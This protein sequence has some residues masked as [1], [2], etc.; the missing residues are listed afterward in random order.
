MSTD[1]IINFFWIGEYLNK[2]CVLTLKS[3]L[4]YDH[5]VHLWTYEKN[6][7]NIIDGVVI[8]DANEILNY[9]KVFSYK[10]KGD[11]LKGTYGGFSDI[12][13]YH[14]INNVGG[15]YCDTDVTCL[16]NFSDIPNQEYILRPHVRTNCVA[17]IFKSPKNSDFLKYCIEQT[18]KLID[19]NNSSWI[20][21]LNILNDCVKKF[22]FEK[23]IVSKNYFGDE[24]FEFL[25]KILQ[26]PYK[27][28]VVLPTHAIHWCNQA[29]TSG[30]WNKDIQRNWEKTMPCTLF[31]ILLRKHKIN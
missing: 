25:E 17:N 28:D 6:I 27:N 4:D 13:R 12:F 7:L 26:F 22:N 16:K 18:E 19:E 1:N 30:Y 31:S 2:N 10:G 11:C 23:Y 24:Q 3:F 8:K 14:L 21:P 5:D 9:S 15:W 29:V 20:K